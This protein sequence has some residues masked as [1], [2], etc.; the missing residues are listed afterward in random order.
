M[1]RIEAQTLQLITRDIETRY[2]VHRAYHPS[3][4]TE[5]CTDWGIWNS[6]S[7]WPA[8]QISNWQG[9][10]FSGFRTTRSF[11]PEGDGT[12]TET[13]VIS[14]GNG[15]H[16]KFTELLVSFEIWEDR[17]NFLILFA[18]RFGWL[19]ENIAWEPFPVQRSWLE[20]GAGLYIG[21]EEHIYI[22]IHIYEYIDIDRTTARLN[23]CLVNAGYTSEFL[24]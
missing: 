21:E 7:T 23:P 13:P 17:I 5:P 11:A 24:E 14:T 18:K 9:D 12:I 8:P 19:H 2:P 16:W 10:S 15:A 20:M 22:Y 4:Y 3:V 6:F 1:L